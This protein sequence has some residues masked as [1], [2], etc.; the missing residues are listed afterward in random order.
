MKSRFDRQSPGLDLQVEQSEALADEAEDLERLASRLVCWLYLY[1]G[2]LLL[3]ISA[4]R[5]P[6]RVFP[7]NFL[8]RSV[9]LFEEAVGRRVESISKDYERKRLHYEF[10]AMEY[11]NCWGSSPGDEGR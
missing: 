1:H 6:L 3:S 10:M 8:L 2:S 4:I 9:V 11:G 7:F 5:S